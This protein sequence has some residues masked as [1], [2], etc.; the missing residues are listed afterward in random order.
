MLQCAVLHG[1][2]CGYLLWHGPFHGLQGNNCSTMVCPWSAGEYLFWPLEHL[3]SPASFLTLVLT[4]LF[5][6]LFSP[7]FLSLLCGVLPFLSM[8]SQRHW[9]YG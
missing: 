2:Q 7:S 8:F 3:L 9:Q 1:L 6:T 4:G 5:P